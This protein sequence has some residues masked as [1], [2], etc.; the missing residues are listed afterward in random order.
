MVAARY[1]H[2]HDEAEE[3]VQDVFVRAWRHAHRYDPARAKVKT[4]LYR[5]AVNLCIDRQRRF[6][7]R[8]FVGLDDDV[9]EVPDPQPGVAERLEDRH[10]LAAVRKAIAALPARQRM[11]LLLSTVGELDSTD[12]AAAMETSRGAVEQLLVRARRALRE[13]LDQDEDDTP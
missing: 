13:T 8:H 2:R 10:R 11:A 1:L 12:V 7:F 5:I 6:A 9:P 3:V 4:W